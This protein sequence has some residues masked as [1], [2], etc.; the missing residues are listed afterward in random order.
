MIPIIVG[1]VAFFAAGLVYGCGA[2]GFGLV[3]VPVLMMFFP[4]A[5]VVPMVMLIGLVCTIPMIIHSR[6]WFS[7]RIIGT[8]LAGALAA[9]PLGTWILRAVDPAALKVAVG[10]VVVVLG[11]ALWKG[12][13][14]PLRNQVA[15]MLAAGF[16]SGLLNS[17]IS[18]PGPP[19]VLF[20]ANQGTP[21]D[22]FRGSLI[23]FF[24]LLN[25]VTLTWFGFSGLLTGE[26]FRYVA[27]FVPTAVAG[28]ILGIVLSGRIPEEKFNRFVVLVVMVTGATLVAFNL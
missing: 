20:L 14:R 16:G 18:L 23:G 22:A 15:G 1:A 13:R 19:V 9:L 7:K 6:K 11:F 26:V 27:T 10:S 3:S 12:W 25:V 17:S 4:P 24:A 21:K 8:M 5:V 28:T 2:F